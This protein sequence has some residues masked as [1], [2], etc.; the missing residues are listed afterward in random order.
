MCKKNKNIV[1][2]FWGWTIFAWSWLK[3]DLWA[4]NKKNVETVFWRKNLSVIKRAGNYFSSAVV[5]HVLDRSTTKCIPSVLSTLSFYTYLRTYVH[6][7][8]TY[9]NS[10]HMQAIISKCRAN[11]VTTARYVQIIFPSRAEHARFSF[12]PSAKK[13][14]KEQKLEINI[15]HVRVRQ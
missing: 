11:F 12:N 10:C 7:Y 2:Y 14:L 4:N 8:C 9:H 3:A 1:K 15:V 6:T 5:H 13:K